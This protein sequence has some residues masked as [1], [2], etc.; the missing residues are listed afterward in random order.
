MNPLSK[1]RWNPYVVGACSGCVSIL[2]VWVAGGICLFRWLEKKK[3]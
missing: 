2:S 1:K 3:L